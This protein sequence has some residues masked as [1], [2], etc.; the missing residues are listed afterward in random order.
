MTQR[1]AYE[2][3]RNTFD[4]DT[5]DTD[6][7]DEAFRAIFGRNPDASEFGLEWSLMCAATE[8][9]CGCSTRSEHQNTCDAIE[10]LHVALAT[11]DLS[12]VVMVTE[13]DDITGEEG[14]DVDNITALQVVDS[15]LINSYT[16]RGD[17]YLAEDLD[18]T[19]IVLTQ[20]GNNVAT[21][22]R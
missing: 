2:W 3:V 1:Q 19:E 10:R 8:G 16:Q 6:E 4:D 18:G 17:Y 11:G 20:F 15:P 14:W 13:W 21:M 12:D 7:R 5:P 9:L 22:T